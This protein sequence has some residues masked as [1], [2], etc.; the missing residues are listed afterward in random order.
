MADLSAHA[1]FL[2]FRLIIYS[3]T[4]FLPHLLIQHTHSS[5]KL[6][7]HLGPFH[8]TI[9]PHRSPEPEIFANIFL[10]GLKATFNESISVA[11]ASVWDGLVLVSTIDGL[12]AILNESISAAPTSISVYYCKKSWIQLPP[13][14]GTNLQQ[15]RA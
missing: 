10:G 11:L 9:Y 4:Q 5:G 8:P 1:F 13:Q 7:L 6:T 3:C 2:S 12:Q 15:G 14:G